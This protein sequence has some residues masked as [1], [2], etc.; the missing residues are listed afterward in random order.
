MSFKYLKN[1]GLLIS[2][3]LLGC[4]SKEESNSNVKSEVKTFKS[5]VNWVGHWQKEGKRQKLVD[6]VASEFEFLNQDIKV[7]LLYMDS[8][9]LGATDSMEIDLI[10]KEA[11]S[12]NPR[13]DIIRV[14]DYYSRVGNYLNDP[15]WSKKYLVDFS[16]DPDFK[17][18]HQEFLLSDEYKADNGGMTIGPYNEGFYWAVWYNKELANKMGISVKTFGMTA[19]DFVGY[20]KQAHEY[21][22]KHNTSIA[23]IYNARDWLT[24]DIL[25]NQLFYSLIG[26]V[27]VIKN[28]KYSPAKLRA[29]EKVLA[30][31]DELGKYES[32]FKDRSKI[33]WW[34][35]LSLPLDGE[36]LFYIQGS[37]MYNI[38]DN[39]DAQKVKRMYPAEIPTMAGVTPCY[40]GGFKACWAVLKNAKHKEEA[41]KLLKYWMSPQMSENW[42]RYT[43]CPT[44]I[45][46]NLAQVSLGL[47]QFE[48]FQY[49]LSKKFDGKLIKPTDSRYILGIRN[50][51]VQISV[52]D[53]LEHKKSAAQLMSEIKRQLK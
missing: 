27:D 18:T 1:L 32:S 35:S 16:D 38:W 26:N 39:I 53:I 3:F 34:P 37:W 14:K 49:Q 43:K 2:L 40:P 42:V 25:V 19:D 46:G 51:D 6:E 45:K 36:C 8:I 33:G 13:F 28:T 47:D 41:I 24:L 10:A 15:E 31:F 44:G 11:T 12:L 21:N 17:A 20:V 4:E 48:D 52:I 9:M 30:V 7:N 22:L 29:L 5:E 23:P 50:K